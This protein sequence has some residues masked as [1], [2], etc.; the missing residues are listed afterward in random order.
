MKNL[1]FWMCWFFPSIG[2]TQ[3]LS[4]TV[5][6]DD[7]QALIGASVYWS[8][9]KEN[10]IFTDIEGIFS[11]P[12]PVKGD[13]INISYIG[14]QT[15]K[16][17]IEASETITIAFKLK[18]KGVQMEV[19]EISASKAMASEFSSMELERLDVYLNPIS[20]GDPLRAIALLPASTNA[21]ETAM[22]CEAPPDNNCKK[23]I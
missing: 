22:S 9:D 6:D 17:F 23:T 1:I 20:S 3:T 7:G 13:T 19:L 11:I 2:I 4:G 21:D 16:Q 10:G 14:F 18:A 5:S 15:Q 8:S 12:V